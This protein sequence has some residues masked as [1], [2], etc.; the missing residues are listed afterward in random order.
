MTAE[1]CDWEAVVCDDH[2]YE[3]LPRLGLPGGRHRLPP[4]APAHS[5]LAIAG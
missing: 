1:R 4:C 2:R 3:T 5:E